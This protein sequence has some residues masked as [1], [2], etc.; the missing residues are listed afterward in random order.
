PQAPRLFSGTL[1]EN[2]LLGAD[3]AAFGPAVDTAVL[4]PDLATLEEGADTV[5]GPRGLRLS[6]GQLQRAAI[7]RMLA[8]DPEL[9]VLDDVSSALDPDTERL[10]WQR[11]LARGPTV[12][13]V[14]HRPALLRAAARVVVLKDGR[15]E[16]AGTLEE[17]LSASPEMRRIWTG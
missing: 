7:A 13:A 8:R 5:V 3:G 15:V 12:L 9:L 16:A 17:V 1:R 6:G 11:L 2:I 14:S 10:L 4:G